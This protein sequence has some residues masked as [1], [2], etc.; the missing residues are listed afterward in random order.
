MGITCSGGPLSLS[1]QVEVNAV[2]LL[3]DPLMPQLSD[4]K[5][6]IFNDD[7]IYQTKDLTSKTSGVGPAGGT[8]CPAGNLIVINI[9]TILP[10]R[11]AL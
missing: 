2:I 8:T 4:V 10:A 1:H 5:I 3:F 11:N 7:G 6:I 9:S